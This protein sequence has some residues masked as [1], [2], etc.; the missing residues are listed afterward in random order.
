LTQDKDVGHGP[1]PHTINSQVCLQTS[2]CF[3]YDAKGRSPRG[4]CRCVSYR[5]VIKLRM[6]LNILCACDM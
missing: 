5:A 3:M 4:M 1:R 6:L 2:E